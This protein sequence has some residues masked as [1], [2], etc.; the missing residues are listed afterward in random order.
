MPSSYISTDVLLLCLYPFD[1]DLHGD[2]PQQ[3]FSDILY[4]PAIIVWD[5]SAYLSLS[6]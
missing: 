2:K 3:C 1:I 4:L 6:V 5:F